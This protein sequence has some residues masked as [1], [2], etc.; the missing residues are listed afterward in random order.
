[1]LLLHLWAV[2]ALFPSSP[3]RARISLAGTDFKRQGVYLMPDIVQS[4]GCSTDTLRHLLD[5]MTKPFA[6]GDTVGIKI[7]W[8]EKGNQNF[9][10]PRY[11][12]TIVKWLQELGVKPFVF[13]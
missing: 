8:G 13:D 11:T 3:C 2:I 12:R 10:H 9:L 5:G 1:M 7:H 6:S 4:C